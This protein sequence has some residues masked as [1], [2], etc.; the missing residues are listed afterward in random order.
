[1]NWGIFERMTMPP[2][3]RRLWRRSVRFHGRACRE[4]ALGVRA[5]ETALDRLGL[6]R[7]DPMRLACVTERDG[8]CVDAIQAC[9]GCTLG[10]KHLLFYR[11]G[12]LI[13]SVYDLETGDSVRIRTREE[14]LWDKT[15]EQ[16]L[17]LET[18][19]LFAFEE[20]HPLTARVLRK[21]NRGCGPRREESPRLHGS[22]Q[23]SSEPFRDFDESKF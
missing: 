5:C 18:E 4:L 11:T 10:K 14:G 6:T 16:I 12:K 20:A 7:A 8:C 23:D 17:R 2:R 19:E 3:R 1:M 21:V 13:F 9:L 15:P 22:F